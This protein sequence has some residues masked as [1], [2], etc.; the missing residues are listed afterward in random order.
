MERYANRSGGSGVYAYS[1]GLDCIHVKFSGNA[2]IYQYS[3]TGK[4]GQKH[5]DNMKLL[6]QKGSGLNTYINLHVKYKYD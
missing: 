1:I 2:K 6:A 3:Y 5:V 4:A